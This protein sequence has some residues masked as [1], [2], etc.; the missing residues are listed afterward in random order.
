MIFLNTHPM[1]IALPPS[2]FRQRFQGLAGS[3][4]RTL[5]EETERWGATSFGDVFVFGWPTLSLP[6]GFEQKGEFYSITI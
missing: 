6:H 5:Q 1:S 4:L 2:H 3:R